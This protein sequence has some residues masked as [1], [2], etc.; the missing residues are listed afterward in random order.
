MKPLQIGYLASVLLFPAFTGGVSA[1]SQAHQA[2]TGIP[3]RV[4]GLDGTDRP[5][6]LEGAGCTRSICSRVFLRGKT[7][8]GITLQPLFGSIASIRDTMEKDALLVMRDGSELRLTLLPDFRVFYVTGRNGVREKL[9]LTKIRSLEL[10][11]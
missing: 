1:A 9:D 4:I 10:E 6:T 11:R 5:V 3:A 2:R 8:R 7:D